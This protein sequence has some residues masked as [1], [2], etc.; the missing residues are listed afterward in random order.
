MKCL[1]VIILDSLGCHTLI[2]KRHDRKIVDRKME[3]EGVV[4]AI[5]Q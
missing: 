3:E 2:K 1:V 4:L 5:G